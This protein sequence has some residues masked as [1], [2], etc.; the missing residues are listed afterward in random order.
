M[1]SFRLPGEAQKIDRMMEK[2][3]QRYCQLNP[4][5]FSNT[6]QFFNAQNL[7]KKIS[8]FQNALNL[9]DLIM[10]QR[11]KGKVY[12]LINNVMLSD[13][14]DFFRSKKSLKFL[15]KISHEFIYF[16]LIWFYS[17]NP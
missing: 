4:G 8:L 1:W 6:G 5:V 12:S 9:Y 10:E 2:F 15:S 3:A 7:E 13:F 11:V 17:L 16:L 14:G